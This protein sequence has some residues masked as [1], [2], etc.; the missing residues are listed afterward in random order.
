MRALLV[1]KTIYRGEDVEERYAAQL[2]YSG[3]RFLS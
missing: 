3:W 2:D 1:F